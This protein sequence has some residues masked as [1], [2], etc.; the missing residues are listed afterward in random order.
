M[1]KTMNL[2]RSNTGRRACR[3]PHWRPHRHLLAMAATLALAAPAAQA[4]TF[5][6]TGG[7][8]VPGLTAPSPLGAADVLDIN[9]G[10]GKFFSAVSFTNAGTVN[11]NADSLYLQ[12][13]AAVVNDALWD[14]TSDNALVYNG[15]A[16]PSF[17][18]NGTFRKSGGAGATTINSSVGFFNLGTLD[19]QT[20]SIQFN[21]GS[22]FNAGS[23]FTGAGSV[24]MAA[25]SNTFNGGFTSSNLWLS[26]GTHHGVGAVVGGA[27]NWTGGNLTGT[28]RV[29][30]GQT[31][32]GNAGSS[33]FIAGAT[34][35][36]QGTLAWHTGEDLY[37]QSGG[38]LRNEALFVANQS[39]SLTYNGGAS[40]SIENTATGTMRAAA[41]STLTVGNG[42]GLVN[43]GGT[44]DAQAGASIRY[45]GGSVFNAGTQFSGAGSNVAAGN[46][47][48]NGAIQ[49]G[50][51]VLEAGNHSGGSAVVH[52]TATWTGGSL[53]GGWT[54]ASG[55]TL[56]GQTG[57]AQFLSG[58]VLSN[59][60]TI[61][62]ATT[63]PLY[64]MSGAAVSNQG[65]FLAS[66][67]TALVYNGGASTGFDNTASGTVRAAAGKTLTIGNGAGLVNNGGTLDAQAGGSIR[68]AGGSVFNA[69]TQF[70][71]GGSHVAAGN[72][73]FNGALH[74]ANLVLEG[75]I[76]SG[77]AAVVHGTATW[78]GGSLAGSWTVASGQ[79]LRG[80]TG[81]SQFLAGATLSNLGTVDWAT[82]N[83]LYLMSGAAVSN[84][85]LFLA[86][87]TT[88]LAYN[89]GASTGFDNTASGTMRAA[90]GKT[91]TIGN[92]VGLVNNGGVLD[93][94]VGGSIVYTGGSVFNAGTQFTGTGSHVATGN[95]TWN[96]PSQ[97]AHLVLQSGVHT[98]G[99]A[100][101]S[102]HT[103]FTGGTLSG[104]WAVA[105]GHS[106]TAADGG[107]KSVSGAGS[108][109]S[110][111][112]SLAW[113]TADTLY[114]M[115]GA[116]FVNQGTLDFAADGSVLYN[117]GAA[118]VFTNS[119]LIVK[120]GGTGTSTIGNTL[121]FDNQGTI[122]VQSGTLA[123]P[124]N[125]SNHG[126]L[127]GTGSYAMAGTLF[128][129]GT[130]APGASPGTLTLQGHY[131]QA[132]AGSFAV[133]LQS[134][135]SHDLFTISGTAALGGTLALSCFANCSY[136]VG[137][138][139]TIL[140]SAGDLG[141]SFASVT[142]SG[143]GSGAFDVIYD[144]VGDRV[145]LRVTQAV[146]AVP[147]PGNWALM[148][149]GLLALGGVLRRRRSA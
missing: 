105:A 39:V 64:L 97:S 51:L 90:A 145:Q 57:G 38:V 24:N 54:V 10:S 29:A 78:T 77:G 17:V 33:K 87:E 19:A 8:F 98:G 60:G 131:E 96:G 21:G 148:A 144:T 127:K 16:S 7:N 71:G 102:G 44:L 140:D 95:N 27:V 133:D 67:T 25:G 79:T 72:N 125:F 120:S 74:A 117:G 3:H 41:G 70:T 149:A 132:A 126:T 115:S 58:T 48:F 26:G 12:S 61:D 136:A 103:T 65:L 107:G 146:T 13:G 89:G 119:G 2:P 134:M 128:N 116:A 92:L 42:V 147:E 18:N 94:Q 6:W 36:N 15:G 110:N 68:Y 99:N 85:G 113:S 108:V 14:A 20:G 22:V 106:L 46:N 137:D 34:L 86:S 50:N 5:T 142:L 139:L 124:T 112:G 62:W 83:P 4:L 52:G 66:E 32:N 129:A 114:L 82:T 104:T 45:A 40:T 130:V 73:S 76:H 63:N 56:R 37:L 69:G 122:D 43:N 100:M 75:G 11:W 31:L 141:G 49:S 135:A 81:G 84:Q 80:Q 109:L 35:T 111:Q 101:L 59:L 143:F 118:P 88:T 28:W 138:V 121:N 53:V 123:L 30:V 55:H 93:A 9:A 23:V 47:S 91:L 1:N